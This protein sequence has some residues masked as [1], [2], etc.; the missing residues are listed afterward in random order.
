ME[1]LR[2]CVTVN[3]YVSPDSLR[4]RAGGKTS[5]T[6]SAMESNPRKESEGGEGSLGRKGS[7][8]QVAGVTLNQ[9]EL[10]NISACCLVTGL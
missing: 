2:E 8:S 9:T 4:L 3:V 1:E 6:D 10:R 5:C 7:R